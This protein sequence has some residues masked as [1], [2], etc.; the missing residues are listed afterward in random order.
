MNGGED[1]D[2]TDRKDVRERRRKSKDPFRI[3]QGSKA[4]TQK[5][6]KK[7]KQPANILAIHLAR[8]QQHMSQGHDSDG[9]CVAG[10]VIASEHHRGDAQTNP[11]VTAG[12][13]LRVSRHE[14]VGVDHGRGV[15]EVAHDRKVGFVFKRDG[16]HVESEVLSVSD[17]AR[18][19]C[20]RLAEGFDVREGSDQRPQS[21]HVLACLVLAEFREAWLVASELD[22]RDDG[23]GQ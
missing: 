16:E 11:P 20:P 17:D 13:A 18:Q 6:K 9:R 19:V 5:K 22:L 1:R 3:Q 21:K 10:G 2:K 7:T 15:D 23:E 4:Q 14:R 8:T 12:Q